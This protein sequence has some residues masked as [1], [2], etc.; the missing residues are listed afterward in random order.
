MRLVAFAVFA[1]QPLAGSSQ[2]K[3]TIVNID[4]HQ[5][6][7]VPSRRHFSGINSQLFLTATSYR[8]P[9]FQEIAQ[10]LDLGWVR[11]PGGTVDDVYD[12]KT[13]D[14]RDDWIAQ[15]KGTKT[16]AY[17]SFMHDYKMNRGKGMTT[18]DDYADFLG[19][20]S[21]G[22][23]QTPGASATHTIGVINTF[24]DTPDSAA[25]LVLAAKKKHLHVD[26]WELG[27]EPNYFETFYPTATAYLNKVEPFAKAVRAADP[28]ARIAVYLDR[29]EPWMHEMSVYPR[30]F[31]DEIYFHVYPQPKGNLGEEIAAY[32]GFLATMSNPYI[33]SMVVSLFGK[34]VQVEVSE[35]NINDVRGTLYSAVFVAEYT[36]RLSSDPHV[37]QVGMHILTGQSNARSAAILP[38]RDYGDQA[39]AAYDAGKVL[40]T[41]KLDFGYYLTPYGLALQII[42]GVINTCSGLWPTAVSGGSNIIATYQGTSVPATNAIYAQAYKM[43]GNTVHLLVTNKSGQPQQLSIIVDGKPLKTTFSLASIGGSNPEALNTGEAPNAVSIQDSTAQDT[44]TVP[45][46]A[47]MD[48]HWTN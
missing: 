45:P 3:P 1:F 47:V 2:S 32:N 23:M 13:G 26:V 10:K 30:R 34:D 15:F 27:N 7:S 41:T 5:T 12:W 25:G 42:D 20:M 38:T 44:V 31:W 33:D 19:K 11:F 48:V 9:K 14:L 46:F 22:S 35:F 24:T 6:L 40:D 29:K 16:A 37:T 8:D 36:V 4:T 17:G 21:T 18:L 39:A 28:D 43:I